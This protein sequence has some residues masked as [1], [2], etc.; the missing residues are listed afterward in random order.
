MN[1]VAP[2]PSRTI[3]WASCCATANTASRSKA[4][5][6]DSSWV[7]GV[8]PARC[9][10]INTK[11]S[12]V[13]VSPSI[14]MRLKERSAASST[15]PCISCG[16]MAA[17]VAMKPSIVAMFGRIM[18]APLLMPETLTV[19]PP[20]M[21]WRDAALGTVSVVMM[22]S[23]A[24]AQCA[25]FRSARAAGRPASMRSFGRLS[26]MTPVENGSTCSGAISRCCASATQVEK[27]R[28]SPSSPVPALALPVLMRIARVPT[29]VARC[30]R[31]SCTGAAQKRLL[32]NT[33]ATDEPSA[34]VT[35]VRSR[36]FALRTPAIAMPISTPATACRSFGF[37]ACRFTGTRDSL[38][39]KRRLRPPP[40]R[41][42][43]AAAPSGGRSE[44]T[45]GHHC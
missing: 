44:A 35:T 11:E 32:V 5:S 16:A 18:P 36:R 12:L 34:S 20:I 17:S 33:P 42:T 10:A 30:L 13:E 37:G 24:S 1:F 19:L 41:P 39:E 43:A 4:P 6:A 27:A 45:W 21:S 23:A 2:S 3:A 22:A 9:V 28:T 31:H 7:I 26:M 15:S 38:W 40:G 14:V 25:A 29:P 8:L